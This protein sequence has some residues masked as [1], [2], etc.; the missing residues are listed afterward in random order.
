MGGGRRKIKFGSRD[1]ANRMLRH[2]PSGSHNPST[3]PSVAQRCTWTSAYVCFCY[4]LGTIFGMNAN[5][6]RTGGSHGDQ[7]QILM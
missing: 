5:C 3:P 1:V 6:I 4:L 2:R 7:R